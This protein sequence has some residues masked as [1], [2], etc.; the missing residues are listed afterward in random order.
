M[1]E[2]EVVVVGG[3]P[4]GALAAWASAK[5]G[6]KTVLLERA[7]N[8]R[9]ACA[10]LVSPETAKAL[11]I[12]ANLVLREIS[13]LR[14][15]SPKGKTYEIRGEK[16]KG[17]VL[18]RTGLNRWLRSRAEEAGTLILSYEACA[19]RGKILITKK[20]AVEFAVL[21]GA[22]GAR[23]FVAK[24]VGLSSPAE[25]LVGIQAEIR[26]ELGDTAE[27]HLGIVP[28]F[29]AWAVPAEEGVCRVG[30]ATSSGRK[31]ILF[32]RDFLARRFP[33]AE[34]FRIRAGLIP[35]GPPART[36]GNWAILV[37]N[38]AAQVKPLTGGGLAF[39]AHCA[40]LAGE[41]AAKGEK[42][43][44]EYEKAWRERVGK[45]LDFGLRG[46]KLF[47]KLSPEELEQILKV[48]AQSRVVRFLAEEGEIDHLSLLPRKLL[49]RPDLW[50]LFAPLATWLTSLFLL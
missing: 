25:I 43:L 31:A 6:A 40:P 42:A 35:I 34:V 22:D 33:K 39:I 17:V 46:R 15:F 11:S 45:E 36:T 28:D 21:V 10:G 44:P 38:A 47:L 4:A 29:F 1:I 8:A 2:G 16:P 12:P 48:L 18:D 13:A 14:V 3:G 20:E 27:I 26:A 49:R 9:A 37:G 41:M 32:L 19:L 23:S 24:A 30:L 50:P 7:P 5:R